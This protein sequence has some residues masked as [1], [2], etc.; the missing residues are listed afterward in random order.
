MLDYIYIQTG[1]PSKQELDWFFSPIEFVFNDRP[2][3]VMIEFIF[4]DRPKFTIYK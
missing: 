1:P 3:F 2:K 4:N